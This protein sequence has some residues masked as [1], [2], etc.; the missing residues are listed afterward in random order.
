MKYVK[1]NFK[2]FD[3]TQP[4][5]SFMGSA[6]RGAFGYS[7]KKIVCVNP[8]FMCRDCFARESCLYYNFYEK[9]N[10]YHNYRFDICLDSKEF[11]FNLFLFGEACEK[12]PYVASSIHKML[13]ETGI[14][15]DRK[16]S[17]NLNINVNGKIIFDGNNFSIPKDYIKLFKTEYYSPDIILKFITPFRSK[18]DNKLLKSN[19]PLELILS[20]VQNRKNQIEG[21]KNGENR[22]Y[23]NI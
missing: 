20:S 4:L 6:L 19:P 10:G 2:A 22:F 14:G 7:L 12:L 11:D 5:Q 3:F 21:K 8:S 13:T 9:T 18:K 1:I 23:S 17:K 16:I 15:K